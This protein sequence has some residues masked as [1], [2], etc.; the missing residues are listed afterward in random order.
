[1]NYKKGRSAGYV[2][3][4]LTSLLWGTTWVASKIGIREMPVLQ[5]TAIRQLIAGM[6]MVG[7]FMLRK[8]SSIPNRKQFRQIFFLSLFMFV[9]A[10][11]LS[12]WSLIYIPA[13]LS[14]LLG[15]LYPLSVVV[16]EFLFF[17]K[18]GPDLL[19]ILGFILGIAGV[20][21]VFYENISVE[22]STA[23]LSGISLSLGA[24]LSWSMG[25][26]F[27]TNIKMEM[28]PYYSTGWQMI[29]S[30]GMLYIMAV[31]VQP[32]I[33]ISEIS[34]KAWAV[35]LYLVVFGSIIAFAAFI[36]SMKRLPVTI[37][38]LYAYVNPLV[39]MVGGYFILD[40]KLTM[41]IFW[42]AIVTLAGVFI[43]NYGHKRSLEK[44]RNELP[45]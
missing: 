17:R 43:V 5:M 15:A 1:M 3:L 12:T 11:G 32:S 24:M 34:L 19:M 27:I 6:I 16:I 42:G 28:N 22:M 23:F 29:I 31:L 30:S 20:A 21:I 10:N 26:I 4:F 33:S 35:I 40:E 39:A 41:F 25:T 37:A 36:F 45:E 44:I 13:G 8:G 7:Y 14:A 18:K 2:A 9:L 38:S